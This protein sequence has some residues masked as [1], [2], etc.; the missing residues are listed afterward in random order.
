[1]NRLTNRMSAALSNSSL[2]IKLDQH[3]SDRKVPIA[4]VAVTV[5]VQIYFWAKSFLNTLF[6][7]L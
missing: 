3:A 4:D 7:L 6:D 2:S 1:M 5:P